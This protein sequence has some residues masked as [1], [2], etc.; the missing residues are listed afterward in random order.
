MKNLNK[1]HTEKDTENPIKR[2]KSPTTSSDGNK[3]SHERPHHYITKRIKYGVYRQSLDHANHNL[4]VTDRLFSNI[5]HSKLLELAS[6]IGAKT[7]ARPNAVLGGSILMVFG[8]LTAFII[9][10]YVGFELP[11]SI[12]VVLYTT[13]FILSIALEIIYKIVKGIK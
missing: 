7:I 10:K 2:R 13:G 6:E 5:A 9:A 8:G 3:T 4:S 12:L 11:F 1:P